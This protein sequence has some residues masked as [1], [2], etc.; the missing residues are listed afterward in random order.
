[1]L[2]VVLFGADAPSAARA[3]ESP[4]VAYWCGLPDLW[5][6]SPATRSVK[7]VEVKAPGDVLRPHQTRWLH[8]LAECGIECGVVAVRHAE[9]DPR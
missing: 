3:T 8:R 4:R 9:R 7:L 6:F 5:L 2:Q 1:M